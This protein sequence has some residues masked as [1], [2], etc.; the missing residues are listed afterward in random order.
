MAMFNSYV[1]L[2]E[3]NPFFL[4]LYVFN[5]IFHLFEDLK[6]FWVY[7]FMSVFCGK[8]PICLD[9]AGEKTIRAGGFRDLM[10]Q[11]P[12]TCSLRLASA[13]LKPPATTRT[14]LMARM[15]NFK[16]PVVNR[17]CHPS[18]VSV[19]STM[20]GEWDQI[21]D[22][23]LYWFEGRVSIASADDRIHWPRLRQYMTIPSWIILN[24]KYTLGIAQTKG[25]WIP[26][27]LGT[28]G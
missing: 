12:P 19:Q 15:P 23:L 7:M 3:G 16:L 6:M 5:N 8:T 11:K 28:R 1:K 21:D 22:T 20:D 25:A 10:D 4:S 13:R 24:Q 26:H 17:R 27:W 2:P 18:Y 9:P 14:D